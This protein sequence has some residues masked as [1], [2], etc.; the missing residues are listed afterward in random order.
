MMNDG[1]LFSSSHSL[2]MFSSAI[3]EVMKSLSYLF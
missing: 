1:I 3:F 2:F